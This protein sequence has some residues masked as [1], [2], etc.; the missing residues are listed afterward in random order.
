[1]TKDDFCERY[2]TNISVEKFIDL[3]YIITLALQKLKFPQDKLIGA[4]SPY[5]PLLIDIA[6]LT[7]KGCSS[8]YKILTMKKSL[9]NC[10]STRELKWHNE[11]NVRLSINFWD[12]SRKLCASIINENPMKW[13]QYQI[14]RNCLQTNVIV[15]HFKRTVDPVCIYCTTSD[16]LIS[17]LFYTCNVV[18]EFLKNI[19]A[20]ISN[21]GL[22]FN[23]TREQFLFGY[24]DKNSS[25][26]DNYLVLLLKKYIWITKFKEGTNLSIVGFKNYLGYALS[27]LKL[28]YEQKNKP[29]DFNVWNDIYALVNTA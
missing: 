15:S 27:D 4:M 2:G 10:N 12:K 5:K 9:N 6:Q 23:P 20:L 8:Y 18:S 17:H 25:S 24:L 16:E 22:S 3:R 19:F 7:T 28:L 26:P 14:I 29:A 1:M 11:L 21:T 13:L